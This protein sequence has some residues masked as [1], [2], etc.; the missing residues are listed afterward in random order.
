MY[1][2]V[3]GTDIKAH[4]RAEHQGQWS[5]Y[6]KWGCYQTRAD[7]HIIAQK[8][9]WHVEGENR[10]SVGVDKLRSGRGRDDEVTV[11]S[12]LEVMEGRARDSFY[13][14]DMS[15]VW[16]LCFLFYLRHRG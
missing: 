11:G 3:L 6:K 7:G 9:E 13:R 5:T 10:V 14:F 16:S 2:C 12:M 8:E 4:G 15:V 1:F